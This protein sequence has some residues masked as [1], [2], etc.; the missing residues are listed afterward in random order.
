MD[1]MFSDVKFGIRYAPFDTLFLL[2]LYF[3]DFKP[4]NLT[5]HFT[6]LKFQCK[7]KIK[8]KEK[9]KIENLRLHSSNEGKIQI[10][11]MKKKSKPKPIE[12]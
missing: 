10:Q 6:S 3:A 9:N 7:N 11:E 4:S 8:T 12:C 2:K 1:V 5:V